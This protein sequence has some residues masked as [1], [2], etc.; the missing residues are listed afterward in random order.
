MTIFHLYGEISA[1][2]NLVRT[3]GDEVIYQTLEL[4]ISNAMICGILPDVNGAMQ[5]FV[6]EAA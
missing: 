2:I 4:F 1:L 6:R 3:L 5:V